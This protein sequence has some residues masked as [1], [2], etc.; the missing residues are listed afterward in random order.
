M[1]LNIFSFLVLSYYDAPFPHHDPH[2]QPLRVVLKKEASYRLKKVE[3]RRKDAIDQVIG[4]MMM[5]MTLWLHTLN[6]C[7]ILITHTFHRTFSILIP[8][9]H[10]SYLILIL[11]YTVSDPIHLLWQV[12]SCHWPRHRGQGRPQPYGS[13]RRRIFGEKTKTFQTMRFS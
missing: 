10:A 8:Y 13:R 6:P 5:R 4:T 11:M 1:W 7:L 3:V 9:T 2:H 12:S